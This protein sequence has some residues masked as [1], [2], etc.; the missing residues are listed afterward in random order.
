MEIGIASKEYWFKVVGMLQQNWALVE[1]TEKSTTLFF[2]S[3]TSGVFDKLTFG[4]RDDAILALR[5]NG[6]E[7][8]SNDARFQKIARPPEPPFTERAH[9]NG[10]V[11]S[12]GKFWI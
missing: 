5:R 1:A 3:D 2:I 7:L 9:P 12:S 4:N 11:Y 6:F 10:P 8:Y